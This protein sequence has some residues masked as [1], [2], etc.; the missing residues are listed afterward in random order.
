M[1]TL[2]NGFVHK[3]L[4]RTHST[5]EQSCID[6]KNFIP[7]ALCVGSSRTEDVR[8]P[9]IMLLQTRIP[10][11]LICRFLLCRRDGSDLLY[12]SKRRESLSLAQQQ[13]HEQAEEPLSAYVIIRLRCTN[14]NSQLSHRLENV[15]EALDLKVNFVPLPGAT[16]LPRT[17]RR[18]RSNDYCPCCRIILL[19]KMR[20]AL[21]LT[22]TYDP[23][24]NRTSIFRRRNEPTPG[25]DSTAV[26]ELC[27]VLNLKAKT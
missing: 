6:F 22:A 2:R 4:V 14:S 9:N 18:C 25:V 26:F 23:N 15:Q 8:L 11:S 16:A 10:L 7:I 17:P 20:Q 19:W 12:L 3:N 1:T 13:V 21:D 5:S 27:M 24:I